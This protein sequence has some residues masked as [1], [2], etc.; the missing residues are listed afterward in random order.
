MPF[1]L[2][3]QETLQIELL[4]AVGEQLS[5][6]GLLRVA[7]LELLLARLEISLQLLQPQL[8]VGLRPLH[9]L[10]LL[11]QLA[12]LGLLLG[13]LLFQLGHIF[14]HAVDQAVQFVQL[15]VLLTNFGLHLLSSL[16]SRVRRLFNDLQYWQTGWLK[17]KWSFL[18]R[19]DA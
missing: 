9:L 8:V 14:L 18:I 7:L 17:T 5:H 6:L 13:P 2:P 12:D 4:L 19:F 3:E 10:K 15:V 16:F 1:G 11:L